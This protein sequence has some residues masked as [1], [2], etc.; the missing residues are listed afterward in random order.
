MFSVHSFSVIFAVECLS[1]YPSATGRCR[2]HSNRIINKLHFYQI[3]GFT[4]IFIKKYLYRYK[5]IEEMWN[6]NGKDMGK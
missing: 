1:F 6:R 3:L 2:T 4:S 5:L